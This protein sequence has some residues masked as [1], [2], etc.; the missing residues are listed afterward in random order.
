ML[1]LAR[2]LI[3]VAIVYLAGAANAQVVYCNSPGVPAGCV[4]RPAAAAAKVL[5]CTAPGVPV[6]CVA[7]PNDVGAP[8]VGVR[9]GIG[10]GA[11]GVGVTRQPGVGAPEVGVDNVGTNGPGVANQNGG[12]NRAGRR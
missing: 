5:Y 11:P 9:P 2:L 10:A 7:R 4:A 6:G 12:V 1:T 8:G 3:T